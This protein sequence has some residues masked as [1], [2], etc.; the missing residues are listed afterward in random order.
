MPLGCLFLCPPEGSAQVLPEAL[1]I[2][3]LAY[4]GRGERMGRGKGFYDRFLEGFEGLRVG[5]C[6]QEQLCH[7][8][9]TEEHDQGVE[10]VVTDRQ[11]INCHKE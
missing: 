11:I 4:T 7:R 5:V 9:P 1:L 8:L 2:P 10:L 6:F 3:G